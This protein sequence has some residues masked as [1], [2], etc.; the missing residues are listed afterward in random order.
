MSP[1]PSR[2]LPVLLT[3]RSPVWASE[4]AC[5]SGSRARSKQRFAGAWMIVSMWM[6]GIGVCLPHKNSDARGRRYSRRGDGLGTSCAGSGRSGCWLGVQKLQEARDGQCPNAV[7]LKCV[8]QIW[9][10]CQ[11]LVARHSVVSP[12]FDGLLDDDVVLG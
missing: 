10:A 6:T 7:E 8:G 9:I 11:I 12:A 5:R 1:S 4:R 2:R 3:T